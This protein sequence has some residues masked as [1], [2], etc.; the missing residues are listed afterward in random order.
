MTTNKDLIRDWFKK[1]PNKTKPKPH[2][3]TSTSKKKSLADLVKE[4]KDKQ[5]TE[6]DQ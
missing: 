2:T 3:H 1:S 5:V 6:G 4:L